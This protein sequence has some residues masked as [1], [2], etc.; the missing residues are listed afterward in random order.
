[1]VKTER[2]YRL[3][4]PK[5]TQGP[6]KANKT[7]SRGGQQNIQKGICHSYPE[8]ERQLRLLD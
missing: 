2:L 1:M 3:T 6:I 7:N 5:Y 8:K 4:F